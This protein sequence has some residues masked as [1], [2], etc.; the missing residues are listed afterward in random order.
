MASPQYQELYKAALKKQQALG[1]RA[2]FFGAKSPPSAPQP[3]PKPSAEHHPRSPDAPFIFCINF[4]LPRAPA[5]APHDYANMVLYFARTGTSDNET[6]ES[7]WAK[8]CQ[9]TPAQRGSRLKL[10]PFILN[11]PAAFQHSIANKPALI[12]NKL[13]TSWFESPN[14]IEC[15]IDVGSSLLASQMWRLMLPQA[16][17]I[18]MDLAWV[19]EGTSEDELPEVVLGCAHLSKPDLS[20][21]KQIKP[22]QLPGSSPRPSVQPSIRRKLTLR[23]GAPSPARGRGEKPPTYARS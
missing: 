17:H 16:K 3:T 8:F 23:K 5:L 4:A 1:R 12:G 7:L 19:I 13:K 14:H 21:F 10:L 6:W 20:N 18:A 11:G 2:S 15:I 22:V 9:M